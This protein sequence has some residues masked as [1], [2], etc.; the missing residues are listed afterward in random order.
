MGDSTLKVSSQYALGFYFVVYPL[1]K[2]RCE[3]LLV[4][5]SQI[6]TVAVL[7]LYRYF[8]YSRFWKDSLLNLNDEI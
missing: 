7:N 8:E 3:L 1:N 4:A 2:E 6:T 5:I